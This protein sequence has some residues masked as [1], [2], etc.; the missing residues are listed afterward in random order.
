MIANK[1]NHSIRSVFVSASIVFAVTL[2][3][4][5]S[6]LYLLWQREHSERVYLEDL[7]AVYQLEQVGHQLSSEMA[8]RF[9]LAFTQNSIQSEEV[10]NIS[11]QTEQMFEQFCLSHP[12]SCQSIASHKRDFDSASLRLFECENDQECL[13][14]SRSLVYANNLLQND[15]GNELTK[16]FFKHL[17]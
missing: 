12:S 14:E 3:I 7:D 13:L 16:V 9:V 4:A 2:L 17:Y 15:I 5:A 1:Q 6:L 10:V 8:R 11:N